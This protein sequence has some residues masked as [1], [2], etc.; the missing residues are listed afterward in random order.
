MV[1]AGAALL[2]YLDA[3]WNELLWDDLVL[4]V[5]NPAIKQWA[6]LPALFRSDLFPAGMRSH[7]YRPLQALSYLLDYQIWGLNPFGFH[8]TSILLHA[9]VAVLL[10]RLGVA[11]LD[12]ARAAL[13][14]ALLFAVHPIHTEAVT[15][16]SG[17][18]DPLAAAAMLIALLS[19]VR[20]RRPA[21]SGWRLLSLAAF[22]LALLAREAAMA[23]VLLIPLADRAVTRPGDPPS[24]PAWRRVTFG[25]LPYA[26][27]LAVYLWL[28]SAA[29][30]A[31]WVPTATAQV[32][33]PLR[34][35]TM[36]KVVV[37]YLSLLLVPVNQHMERVVR[38][39]A[40]VL[41]PFVLGAAIVVG[42]AL[43]AA[44]SCRRLARPVAIG[45]A[46][47]GL[48]L[49]PVANLVPLST[50]MAEHWLYVPSM[51]MFLAAGWA[52]AR[53]MAGAGE[54]VLRIGLLV[55]LAAYGGL[56]MRRN[57]D[58]KDGVTFYQATLRQ[59]P[60]SVRAWTNLGHAYQESGQMEA[61]KAA[62]GR[63]LNLRPEAA[64]ERA[65]RFDADLADPHNNLGNIYRAQ[66]QYEAAL[67]EFQ[68]ALALNPAHSSAYNNLG[69]TLAAMG[70]F[71]EARR[72][73]EAALRLDPG[74]AAAHSNL[75]NQ[76][77]RLDDLARAQVEYLAAI[78]LNPDYAEAYNNLGSVYFRLGNPALAEEA[79]R[80]ALRLNPG[81]DEVRRN[82]EV[83]LRS[84]DASAGSPTK[85]RSP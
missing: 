11:L 21:L 16:V 39:A 75:G 74:S 19:F 4:V 2:V 37:A 20:D 38:P 26:L 72:A 27:V 3:L 33:W 12:D 84:R 56:T 60:S 17:R 52:V 6:G 10:Y 73:V 66:G 63:A 68:Q 55:V 44:V 46:W 13:I 61:A 25:Y 30:G 70:R 83:V 22:F 45:A 36:L 34:L 47:F 7:Y 48:A 81:L 58:W 59:A 67:Q 28:R 49:L 53:G 71:A 41:D 40:S 18:S 8:L 35:L 31:A 23:L 69:L 15:Y 78:R 85:E 43:V 57:L 29:V 77:F 51:G 80:Q 62:Y 9:G 76:Y 79:Y 54:P 14:A 1:V 65:V 82:L 64:D 24:A 42:A 32:A 50:F 5:N